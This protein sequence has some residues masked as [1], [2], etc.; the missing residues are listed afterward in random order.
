M[1]CPNCLYTMR[2][3]SAINPVPG[4]TGRNRMDLHCARPRNG[5]GF[6][7]DYDAHMGVITEDPKEWMCHQYRFEMFHDGR[8]YVF[9]SKDYPVDPYHQYIYRPAT[10][11]HLC[12]HAIVSLNH[13]IPISTGD[14]MHERAWEIFHR[15]MRIN[16]FN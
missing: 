10:W 8:T 9:G 12:E 1:K 3:I 15:L 13:F 5:G 7:C 4:R 11:I 6:G 2:C 16:A 14:D